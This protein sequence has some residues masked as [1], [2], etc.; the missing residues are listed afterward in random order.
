[1][2]NCKHGGNPFKGL[3]GEWHVFIH[4]VKGNSGCSVESNLERGKQGG[5]NELGR[6]VAEL[7]AV[8]S[9]E[10]HDG[11]TGMPGSGITGRYFW[12]NA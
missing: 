3:A 4:T 11:G 7:R 6:D 9:S 2:L 12:Q 1:M 10:G 8:Q 5:R